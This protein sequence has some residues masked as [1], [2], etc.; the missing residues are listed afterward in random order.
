M[1]ESTVA[2]M[3]QRSEVRDSCT[4]DSRVVTFVRGAAVGQPIGTCLGIAE[5]VT[6]A[7]ALEVCEGVIWTLFITLPVENTRCGDHKHCECL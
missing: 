5:T 6:H 4:V 3:K 1:A 2:I 7:R